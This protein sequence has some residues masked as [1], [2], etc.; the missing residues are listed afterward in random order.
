MDNELRNTLYKNR[1]QVSQRGRKLGAVLV[2]AFEGKFYWTTEDFTDDL[3]WE[4]IPE[5]LY[6]ELLNHGRDAKTA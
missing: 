6:N 2:A 4:E 5:T 3:L 1:T